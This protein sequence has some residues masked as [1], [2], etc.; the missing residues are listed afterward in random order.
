MESKKQTEKFR[1]T[2]FDV[3]NFE[4][5]IHVWILTEEGTPLMFHDRFHPVIYARGERV[6]LKKLIRRLSE[7][8]ALLRPPEVVKKRLFYENKYV[9]VIKLVIKRPSILYKIK[10]KLFHFYRRLDIYHTDIE[11]PTG[12]LYY[13]ELHIPGKVSVIAD[14]N[15]VIQSIRMEDRI[16]DFDY[17]IPSMKVLKMSLEHSHRLGLSDKNR[18]LIHID[19]NTYR[20]SPENPVRFLEQV[21]VILERFDPDIILTHFGDSAIFPLFFEMAQKHNIV[22]KLDRDLLPPTRRSIIRKGSSFMTYGSWIYAAPSY[23]L[24]GRWHIDTTNSFVYKETELFGVMELA[25]ISRIPVQKLARSSTGGALTA[26]ETHTALRMD[27]LVPWQKSSVENTKTAYELLQ[28]DRGGLVFS[29]H[30]EECYLYENVAQLD[31]SQ[32]YPTIMNIHNISPETIN[33]TCCDKKDSQLVPVANYPICKKRRGVVS[34]SLK[35]ILARRKFYKERLKCEMDEQS[36]RI[37]SERQNSLKWMLVTSFGYLGY[38]NAKFGRLESHESVTAFG[39]EKLITAK[40]ISE[41]NGF[42]VIHAITDC[43]FIIKEA[44][45]SSENEPINHSNN[46]LNIS[47]HSPPQM[48][49]SSLA[50]LAGFIGEKTGIEVNVDGIYSWLAFF[51]SRTDP[52]VG[53]PTRYMGRFFD[54]QM[55]YRGIAARRKDTPL[56]VREFQELLLNEMAKYATINELKNIHPYMHTLFRH[57]EEDL[58]SQKHSLQSLF[59]RK[60]VSKKSGEYSSNTPN[61]VALAQ[62]DNEGIEVEPGEKIRFLV[63]SD[64][65]NPRKRRYLSEEKATLLEQ[66]GEYPQID[67][68]YY[69][70][71]LRDAYQEVWE[72]FAPPGYF[73]SKINTAPSLFRHD[74]S[75]L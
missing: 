15:N 12:Y 46:N 31:F 42:R 4:D 32:M 38:R 10:R 48:E 19:E 7:L 52:G 8:D 62:L 65:V 14:R 26:I 18:L 29:P 22:L 64:P 68:M 50:K 3:Y 6:L 54:G 43:I 9:E 53:V 61:A 71:L 5:S 28:I 13:K 16:T 45:N 37:Y 39:R 47:F 74:S 27:Y 30:T 60:T 70:K 66:K 2:L 21:N 33:C 25:R 72:F 51:A 56:Y 23:P 69:F 36:R 67:S 44:E 75:I 20:L 57:A 58:L 59:I 41:E 55:K 35:H 17:E 40:D 34:L 73:L 49:S 1:G 63:I 24:F 11:I